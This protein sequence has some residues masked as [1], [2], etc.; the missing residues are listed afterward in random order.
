MILKVRAVLLVLVLSLAGCNSSGEKVD[1]GSEDCHYSQCLAIAKS[2]GER[3]RHCV[4]NKGDEF[5]WQHN[6]IQATT[7]S[8][9]ES[10]TITEQPPYSELLEHSRNFFE[11]KTPKELR[12]LLKWY[13]EMY[14]DST[15]Y[16]W[17]N[18]TK[19]FVEIEFLHPSH[20]STYISIYSCLQSRYGSTTH[21]FFTEQ[22]EEWSNTI[23]ISYTHL[24][25]NWFVMSGVGKYSKDIFYLKVH[26]GSMY[27]SRLKFQYPQEESTSMK[28]LLTEM[29]HSFQSH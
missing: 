6:S 19:D 21:E 22:Y 28:S 2:T 14:T 24:D 25:K 26:D 16:V 27:R 17:D 18:R 9:Q 4:S 10:E 7:D 20:T 13:S 15:D 5:C 29:S 1:R 23:D 8:D 12:Y 3:C 11:V